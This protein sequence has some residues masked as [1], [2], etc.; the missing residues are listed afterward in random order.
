MIFFF[1]VRGDVILR[2]KRGTLIRIF[3][4]KIVKREFIIYSLITFFVVVVVVVHQIIV[5][6]EFEYSFLHF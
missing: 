1:Q 4:F 6:R 5:K 3:V 2:I